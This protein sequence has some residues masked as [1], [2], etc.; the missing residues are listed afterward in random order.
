MPEAYIPRLPNTPF[1]ALASYPDFPARLG[2]ATHNEIALSRRQLQFLGELG[3]PCR[4]D[5]LLILSASE[6][7][8]CEIGTRTLVPHANDITVAATTD[9]TRL[10]LKALS[11]IVSTSRS[12]VP[13]L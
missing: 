7:V 4:V 11:D 3:R 10:V 2:T 9:T 12:A 6:G 5:I 8:L 1:R 13:C